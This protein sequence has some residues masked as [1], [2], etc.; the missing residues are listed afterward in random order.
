MR[1]VSEGGRLDRQT[2][3]GKGV[4]NSGAFHPERLCVHLIHGDLMR[5]S[6]ETQRRRLRCYSDLAQIAEYVSDSTSPLLSPDATFFLLLF[7]SSFCC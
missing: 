1:A 7:V 5:L 2:E 6:W 3:E 4:L